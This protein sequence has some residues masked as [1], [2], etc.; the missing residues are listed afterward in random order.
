MPSRLGVGTGIAEGGRVLALM[1][2]MQAPPFSSGG[3]LPAALACAGPTEAATFGRYVD[4]ELVQRGGMGSVMRA[5]DPITGA[6]VAIKTPRAD[7]IEP[8]VAIRREIVALRRLRVPGV[9]RLRDVGHCD[10]RPWFAM[11]WLDG[12]TL[13]DE[14]TRL[15]PAADRRP[16]WLSDEALARIGELATSLCATISRVHARGFVHCDLKPANVLISR[17]GAPVLADFG[18]ARFPSNSGAR[19]ARALRGAA[20]PWYASPELL[21]GGEIDARSDLYALGCL[22]Y[23][24]VTGEPPLQAPSASTLASRQIT[25]DPPPPSER[26]GGVP[27]RWEDVIM[28]LMRKDREQRPASCGVVFDAFAPRVDVRPCA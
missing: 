23:E 11:D 22:L 4:A 19:A 17:D 7:A 3:S 20:T 16:R 21:L 8:L 25:E 2:T 14:I 9:V 15:H 24:L 6:F 27:P 26:I 5:T 12:G 28:A 1:P 13:A 18:L 10:A